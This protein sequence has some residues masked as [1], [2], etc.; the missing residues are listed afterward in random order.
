MTDARCKRCTEKK[1]RLMEIIQAGHGD[2]YSVCPCS[3]SLG[4]EIVLLYIYIM[5]FLFGYLLYPL[6]FTIIIIIHFLFGRGGGKW[7]LL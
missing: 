7:K 4:F 1:V 5:M 2:R 6:I 3:F